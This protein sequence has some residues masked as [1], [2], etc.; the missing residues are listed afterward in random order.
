M[1]STYRRLSFWLIFALFIVA[2]Q[3]ST[4]S[5]PST[6]ALPA[7]P[8]GPLLEVAIL[9]PTSGEMATF[10]RRL[11]NG[12]VMAFDHWNAQQGVA[13]YQLTWRFYDTNCD[14]ETATQATQ[15]AIAEG[16]RFII[17]PLCSV[18][19]VA[20][21]TVAEAEGA[22]LIAPAATH[23]LVTVNGQGQ[24]RPTVFRVAYAPPWQAQAAAQFAADDLSVKQ[25][26][27]LYPPGDDYALDLAQ[28]FA[29]EFTRQGGRLVFE[30]VV[31]P[32]SPDFS[33]NLAALRS[34]AAQFVYL[35]ASP[36]FVNQVTPQLENK[37]IVFLGN[38]TWQSEQLDSTQIIS[39]YYP[40]HFTTKD[41]RPSIQAWAESYRATYA[42]EPDTL[43][44]LGYDAAYLLAAAIKQAGSPDIERVIEVLETGTF[45][46]VTGPISFDAH[47]NPLKPI[48][49]VQ[50]DANGINF[51]TVVSP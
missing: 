23:P 30:A 15:Q 44:A 42:V 16:H 43:A 29:D 8:S 24:L 34:S 33:D 49:F 36:D 7:T 21:A 2:A 1:L 12:I 4:G 18:A 13:G 28:A 27:L 6:P 46:S 17:G 35:P 22:L 3:C 40:L 47:H 51:T 31:T 9:S 48:P 26:A 10:G 19:A 20:G 38:D 11:Q 25:A 14:F 41:S 37:V 5:A 50:I 32:D 39:G 45:G